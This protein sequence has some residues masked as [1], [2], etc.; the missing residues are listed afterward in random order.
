MIYDPGS[1][2]SLPQTPICTLAL[3]VLAMNRDPVHNSTY[4][5][6]LHVLL[7]F[8]YDGNCRTNY[9]LVVNLQHETDTK[10]NKSCR[11]SPQLL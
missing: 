7:W 8:K 2:G 3:H 6:L 1:T 5:L 9:I 10:W 11:K 4:A